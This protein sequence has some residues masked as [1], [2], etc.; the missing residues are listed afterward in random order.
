MGD[1]QLFRNRIHQLEVELAHKTQQVAN[2]QTTKGW[3]KYKTK[4]YK[5]E[6]GKKRFEF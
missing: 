6:I 1:Y 5:T 3:F 4:K 2:L